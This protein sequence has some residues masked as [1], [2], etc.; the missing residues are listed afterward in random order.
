MRSAR[1]RQN[2]AS[3]RKLLRNPTVPMKPR[4]TATTRC[5]LWLRVGVASEPDACAYA[6]FAAVPSPGQCAQLRLTLQTIITGWMERMRA[7]LAVGSRSCTFNPSGEVSSGVEAHALLLRACRGC[8]RRAEN[9]LLRSVRESW[10]DSGYGGA[11]VMENLPLAVRSAPGEVRSF[12]HRL[13]LLITRC[14]GERNAPRA[15]LGTRAQGRVCALNL[16]L[17]HGSECT[18]T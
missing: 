14:M 11:A 18:W 8:W 10:P 5:P 15:V 4:H 3:T 16:K 12:C 13:R 17:F 6:S 9:V 2:S 7:A 1:Y